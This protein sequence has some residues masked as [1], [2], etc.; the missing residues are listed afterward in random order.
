MTLAEKCGLCSG[1][2]FWRLKPLA[3]LGLSSIMLSDGP[4]G[5]RKQADASD[6]LGMGESI[7]STC[8]PA[9]GTLAQAWDPELCRQ[10][11]EALG[12]E[13]AAE[14]VAVV[15][16]PGI[17]IKRNPLCG[18][19]F[20]YFSEDPLLTGVLAAAFIRGVQSLGVGTSLK[21]FTANNQE[22]FRMVSDTR[23]DEATLREIYLP[24]FE[25]AVQAQP[26]TV[27]C[28]YN[29]L[30]GVYCSDNH[31]LLTA[32][33]REQ[34]GFRGL[35]VSDWG[36]VNDRVVGVAAGMDL[37]MPP[38]GGINDAKVAAA[39]EAGAL[40]VA[41]VDLC[42]SRVV[43]LVLAAQAAAEARV[44]RESAAEDA[45]GRAR[46]KAQLLV[47]NHAFARR[48]AAASAVL[49]RN[50]AIDTNGG[51]PLL[52]LGLEEDTGS[53]AGLT[54]IGHLAVAPR[55]QG[56]GSSRINAA[57]LDAPLAA[58]RE[59][60]GAE[61]R[62]APGY[63]VE[64]GKAPHDD[65][66]AIAEAVEAA[67]A[68][69]TT[70]LLV[71]LP[72]VI[73]CEG[74]DRSDIELPAQMN[75]LV[76][77]VAAATPRLV[78][79]LGGAPVALPWLRRVPCV[80]LLGLAGQAVGGAL[81]DLLSG[82]AEPTGGW[83]RRGRSRS[84]TCRRRAT[85]APPPPGRVPRADGD[86]VPPL[87]RPPR[88]LPLGFGLA[89]TT[90]EYSDLRLAPRRAPGRRARRR[91]G[92]RGRRRH[93][94]RHQRRRARAPRWR[95]STCARRAAARS[96]AARAARV[97]KGASRGGRAPGAHAAAPRR[98]FE[99]WDIEAN[100][101]R[102]AGRVRGGGGVV[103]RGAPARRHAAGGRGRHHARRRQRRWRGPVRPMLPQ[104]TPTPD[105]DLARLGLGPPPDA[106]RPYTRNTV[107]EE[108]GESG[109]IGSLI[110]SIVQLVEARDAA[111][112]DGL[113]EIEVAV[114]MG[115]ESTRA[116][117]C[118]ASRA[119]PTA[120]CRSGCSTWSSTC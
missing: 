11:G 120:A 14:Q 80:L 90:F 36:A 116:L 85:C 5:L 7:P 87:P 52:P 114:K 91:E 105:D 99:V 97:L 1:A 53:G 13:C 103:V 64:G 113:G 44:H 27:M 106:A 55:Y 19:N 100:G 24:A 108:I 33:L 57:H 49:L 83:R 94:R 73:E 25:R 4:H 60:F 3:R 84:Q 67:Q 40:D 43:A 45:D 118:A 28:A 56:A 23:V 38:S 29:R 30:N 47:E 8:F 109:R 77:A 102:R 79:A 51:A 48:A 78:V 98:A 15:L 119:S 42:A 26:W 12:R 82:D 22:F 46:E 115:A 37:E 39:V 32:V 34:W 59:R 81:A 104:R 69:R 86:R 20:E 111:R 112:V 41:A 16:G 95:S 70:V 6:H 65:P 50:E 31:Y 88:H 10:T 62:Y 68:A 18:R 35:V 17:N 110:Y 21:H 76:E 71:G 58:V 9:A 72:S 117:P 63:D 54:V 2:E 74:Y 93:R 61:V 92:G 96:A 66:A 101:W 89:Y 75:A 107:F